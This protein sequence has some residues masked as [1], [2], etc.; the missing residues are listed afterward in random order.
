[1]GRPLPIRFYARDTLALAQELLGCDLWV[2]RKGEIQQA[3]IVEVE[4][5]RGFD[6]QACLGWRGPTPR[7]RSLFGP[8]GRAFVYLTYG[9]HYM[10][11]VVTER[12]G[13]PAGVLIRAIEPLQNVE[14]DTRGPGLLTRALGIDLRDDGTHL[15]RGCVRV[16]RGG[17]R[18]DERIEVS[19]RI[20]I[21]NAGAEARAR[22]WR[23]FVEGSRYLSRGRPRASARAGTSRT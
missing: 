12:S 1:M 14:A 18:P 22:P 4:A 17:L 7:L 9:I 6:D 8:P 21:E 15:G 10:F 23:F 16:L 11:N 2:Q 5:Y 3:R 13:F 19:P 20:G